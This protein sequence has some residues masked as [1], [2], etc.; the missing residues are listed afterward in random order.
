MSKT[1]L[2]MWSA[3]PVTPEELPGLSSESD[4]IFPDRI[5]RALNHTGMSLDL[6]PG[7][8]P[9]EELPP[10][11]SDYILFIVKLIEEARARREKPK[12]NVLDQLIIL[13]QQRISRIRHTYNCPKEIATF[14]CYLREMIRKRK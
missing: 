4:D 12:V 10:A 1:D 11:P 6:P 2:R 8:M 7:I 3:I 13:T 5:S 9:D 14:E